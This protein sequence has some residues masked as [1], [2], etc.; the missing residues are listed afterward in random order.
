VLCILYYCGIIYISKQ[1]IEFSER[2]EEGEWATT[3]QKLVVDPYWKLCYHVGMSN[4]LP[5]KR[6][7][8]TVPN[9][10]ETWWIG[11]WTIQPGESNGNSQW[12]SPM[13]IPME[14]TFD[15]LEPCSEQ[16]TFDF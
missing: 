16:L 11:E 4:I 15:Y 6:K 10:V 1:D 13:D 2:G 12:K 7:M 3:S 9:R 5:F 8:R 14:F